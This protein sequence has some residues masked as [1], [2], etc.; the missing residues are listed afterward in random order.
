[1]SHAELV[2]PAIHV[3]AAVL[4]REAESQREQ[5]SEGVA[6]HARILR[7]DPGAINRARAW[8]ERHGGRASGSHRDAPERIRPLRAAAH[9]G[10]RL[11]M[12]PG[13][14]ATLAVLL[15]LA[16][17]DSL[18]PR[19]DDAAPPAAPTKLVAHPGALLLGTDSG[20]YE[21]R[22]ASRSWRLVLARED[23]RD[24]A[25]TDAGALVASGGRLFEWSAARGD[26]QELSLGA[27]AE[28]RAVAIDAR[29]TA[30]VATATGLYRRSA[31]ATEFA[32]EL[33]IP[34]GEVAGVASA[35]ETVWVAADGALWSGS[36]ARGFARRVGG[37]EE[38]WW[39]LCGAVET[40]DATLLCVPA[41]IWRLGAAEASRIELG[42]GRLFALAAAG[43]RVFVA[44]EAGLQAFAGAE[45]IAGAGRQQLAI[46]AF[47][48][49][50]DRGDLLVATE[51][52]IASFALAS[53]RRESEP[54]RKLR[55]A[56]KRAHPSQIQQLQRAALAYLELSP[57]RL[58][59]IEARARR[60][61]LLPALSASLVY[62]RDTSRGVDHDQV[63]TSG[64][65]AQLFDSDNRRNHGYD[66][67]VSLIWKLSE[68]A[69]P[70]HALAISRERRSLVTL[71]DQVLE[72]VNHLYFQ[73]LR[74]LAEL[75]SLEREDEA[76]R[77]ALEL[78]AAEIA[79]QLDAWSGGVF[80]RLDSNSPLH[81]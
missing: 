22:G 60:S 7:P 48:L 5:Q 57:Q 34:S 51:R 3:R 13:M 53:G 68:L 69:S 11:A 2:D 54:E 4:R 30:W 25:P 9:D 58:V 79:A 29:G 80:S 41:G 75:D 6:K 32:R 46:P 65:H 56:P 47:G 8:S 52:G 49:A 23:V 39:E 81:E 66:V 50:V 33:S 27:G 44:G 26:A 72:R 40:V 70:D 12:A 61:A 1:M 38:G 36:D 43:E 55:I 28:A 37:L 73:R 17:P 71:R 74:L 15:A 77:A 67:G 76:K 24:L 64:V 62:D 59:E 42:V 45:P 31:G 14:S 18:L 21:R 19:W 35:G 16:L 20:L 78:D 10:T 63:F